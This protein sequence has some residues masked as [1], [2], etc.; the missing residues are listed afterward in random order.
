MSEAKYV[1]SGKPRVLIVT[2]AHNEEA[3]LPILAD[4]I[5][6]QSTN[7]EYIWVLVNDNS[8]DKTGS[9]FHSLEMPF[10]CDSIETRSTGKLITGGAYFTWWRG[11]EHGLEKFSGIDYVLKLDADVKLSDSYFEEIY[12]ALVDKPD[13]LGGVIEGKGR[14]QIDSVPGPVKMYS[15]NALNLIRELPVATGFDVMDEVLC[16][17]H[18]LK[19]KIVK[20]ATFSLSRPIGHSQGKLHGRFRNGVVC[21][22]T[23]YA[24]EYFSLHLI[25]Y[26]F[27][28]PWVFGSLWLLFGY[29]SA[30]RGPY[31]ASLREHHRQI[32]RR[33]L[34]V[35]VRN[36]LKSVFQL[37]SIR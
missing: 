1:P 35:I 31:S 20:T 37:Y 36:P 29:I 8:G 23:G 24:P 33:K 25:R 17:L 26:F 7:L 4:S 18:G 5:R 9:L 6:N 13:L 2:P 11:I 30:G 28:S 12:K 15:R 19:V 14:E 16:K 27:R 34:K 21:R 32:Q 3:N 10:E 22:W